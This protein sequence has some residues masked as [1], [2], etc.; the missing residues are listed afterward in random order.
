MLCLC[1]WI[2]SNY[3][4]SGICE[5]DAKWLIID[6]NN[7]ALM[8]GEENG[9]Y[10]ST[11]CEER[12]KFV[13][14]LVDYEDYICVKNRINNEIIHVLEYENPY[15]YSYNYNDQRLEVISV[16]DYWSIIDV[17]QSNDETRL[18][19]NCSIPYQLSPYNCWDWKWFDSEYQHYQI[20][21][22]DC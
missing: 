15:K 17:Q 20:S 12:H 21:T 22:C 14:N 3:L 16:N 19:G 13:C 8:D 10:V 1:E 7:C 18:V 5:D 6:D 2:H 9:N 4:D 11:N